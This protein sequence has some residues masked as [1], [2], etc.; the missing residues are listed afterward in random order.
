MNRW[1]AIE[2]AIRAATGGPFRVHEA[3]PR[4]GGCINETWR[5][6][7]GREAF[8]VK[9]NTAARLPMFEAEAEGLIRLAA[10]GALRVPAPVCRG[11]AGGQAFLVLEYLD[12]EGGP[13]NPDRLGEGLAA[14][15]AVEGPAFGAC[16]DNFI[17]STAQ[18]NASHADWAGFWRE[19]RLRPQLTLAAHNEAPTRLRALGEHLLDAVSVLLAGHTPRP[20]LLHGDLWAGNCGYT[21]AG[22]PVIFDPAV[23][24][25]D[26]ETD[27][28]MTAL[29][30]GF[31]PRFYQAYL[32]TAP[33]PPGHE[34]RQRLYNLY[35]IL[36]HYNL[37]GGAYANQAMR[38]M[39]TLLTEA[40][41]PPP[42]R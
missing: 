3:S 29:F 30:G 10:A 42:E 22:E 34:R 5:I 19:E 12:M 15:H 16:G 28:A 36:N 7:D 8:F 27:L 38:M 2:D 17:G 25:G 37:F 1:A 11:L 32:A 40:G 21:R 24:H 6:D 13:D 18:S 20:S 23:Y 31:A 9:L 4:G 35:H 26:R 14:L 33:L 41:L 39:E